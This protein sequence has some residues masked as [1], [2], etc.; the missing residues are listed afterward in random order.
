MKNYNGDWRLIEGSL[1]IN[2]INTLPDCL[3]KDH[4]RKIVDMLQAEGF[5]SDTFFV[6]EYPINGV[7][8]CCQKNDNQYFSIHAVN[9]VLTPHFTTESLDENGYNTFPC[10]TIKE[11]INKMEC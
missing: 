10:K 8:M 3:E 4:L 7:Y 6:K 11:S 9:D 1:H 5:D 2:R